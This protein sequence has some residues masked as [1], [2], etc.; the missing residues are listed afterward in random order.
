VITHGGIVPKVGL[1]TIRLADYVQYLPKG[2]RLTVTFGDSSTKD[3]AYLGFGSS[4][5]IT[6]GPAILSLQVLTKPVTG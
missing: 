1:N 4:G 6:L 2:T 5:S 3:V